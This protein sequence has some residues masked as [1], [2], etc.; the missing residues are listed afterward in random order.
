MMDP[1]T[2]V[3]LGAG[4]QTAAQLIVVLWRWLTLRARAELTRAAAALPT[5]VHVS[6]R[7]TGGRW[8]VRRG[9]ARGPR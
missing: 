6:A 8:A 7:D 2:L 4:G 1:V 9:A 3:L 5:G